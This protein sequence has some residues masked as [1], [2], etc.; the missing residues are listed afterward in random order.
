[1]YLQHYKPILAWCGRKKKKKNREGEILAAAWNADTCSLAMATTTGGVKIYE[2]SPSTPR[3]GTSFGTGVVG[4]RDGAVVADALDAGRQPPVIALLRHEIVLKSVSST[5]GG[6]N[7]D[8][9]GGGDGLISQAQ[10]NSLAT[11]KSS[12]G[13][14]NDAGAGILLGLADGQHLCVWDIVTGS[15]LLTALAIAQA[16]CK[17]EKVMWHGPMALTALLYSM[18]GGLRRVD[19]HQVNVAKNTT[20]PVSSE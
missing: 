10:V 1:M 14:G 12:E 4:A 20:T 16:G 17:V 15:T 2:I 13:D 18:E 9:G 8:A 19:V 7:G 11:D 6:G 5:T 3:L